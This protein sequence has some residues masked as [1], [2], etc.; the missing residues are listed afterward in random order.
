M[1]IQSFRSIVMILGHPITEDDEKLSQ[2]LLSFA[3]LQSK[4]FNG[5]ERVRMHTRAKKEK[6]ENEQ[7]INCPQHIHNS[8]NFPY[9]VDLFVGADIRID[10]TD[11]AQLRTYVNWLLVVVCESRSMMDDFQEN[12]FGVLRRIS[13]IYVSKIIK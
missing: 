10:E 5:F 7:N 8:V 4:T 1:S 6:K 3:F 13:C 11:Q 12:I 9:T 2:Q